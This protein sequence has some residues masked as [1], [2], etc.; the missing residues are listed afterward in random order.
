MLTRVKA[1]NSALGAL[2]IV[3]S[4]GRPAAAE[5]RPERR[6]SL[7]SFLHDLQ[8]SGLP[9]IFS[10]ALVR[11]GMDVVMK[12][13]PGSPRQILDDVLAPHGLEARDGPDGRLLVVEARR[14]PPQVPPM[15]G[16]AALKLVRYE[17]TVE[18]SGQSALT[19]TVGPPAMRALEVRDTPGGF[20]N[21]FRTL[22]LRPDVTPVNEVQGRFSVRS[23]SPDQNLTVVDGVEVFNPFRLEALMS[24]FD[25][26]TFESFELTTGVMPARYGDRLASVL[27]V[28]G[29]AGRRDRRWQGTT[30]L[31]FT[32]GSLTLEGRLPGN[33]DATWLISGRRTSLGSFTERL[34]GSKVNRFQDLHVRVDWPWRRRGRL[35]VW[36]L[37]GRD[38][39]RRV[40]VLR[41]SS[42]SSDPPWEVE[43]R[44]DYSARNDVWAAAFH[45]ALGPRLS[46][47][48]VFS[49][50]RNPQEA[51]ELELLLPAW[52]TWT[53]RHWRR[54]RL[55][56][57]ALREELAWVPSARQRWEGGFEIHRLETAWTMGG[58]GTLSRWSLYRGGTLALTPWGARG[59]TVEGGVTLEG[60][61]AVDGARSS[62]RSAVWLQDTVAVGE[63]LVIEPGLRLERSSVN[64]ETALSPRVHAAWRLGASTRLSGAWGWHA[65]SPGFEK[66]LLSDY[67]LD[68]GGEERLPVSSERSRQAVLGLEHRFGPGLSAR[69]ELYHTRFDRLI[70][71]RL[72]T[73]A[74]RQRRMGLLSLGDLRPGAMGLRA[75]DAREPLITSV[76][77]NG[78]RG[79]AR[80]AELGLRW[81]TP[82][83]SPRGLSGRFSYSYGR[84]R[85]ESYGLVYPFD[86]DRRHALAL[87]ADWRV[88][89]RW[90]LA[91]TWRAASGLPYTPFVPMLVA[92]VEAV[93]NVL[94]AGRRADEV[95]GVRL[96]D[97][98]AARH[99]FYSRVDL[100]AR[101]ALG[102][103]G[104]RGELYLDVFNALNHN[105]ADGNNSPSFKP[106]VTVTR[107]GWQVVERSRHPIL[108]VPSLGVRLRF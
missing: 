20:R 30:A 59:V 75:S 54:V 83:S 108:I 21:V 67:F 106:I 44:L 8:A 9:I 90:G 79:T 14:P 100:R 66:V 70:V 32:S 87:A 73:D 49:L 60:E 26:E 16:E 25:P 105:V 98:N 36:T 89:R 62:S 107:E 95:A 15:P 51:E 5:G 64:G 101:W 96:S 34:T 55:G 3:T 11:P 104:E 31:D 97:I 81:G 17:E 22:Q 86:Y 27:E 1:W 78:G 47:R 58:Q 6:Q 65:Q 40:P 93:D 61:A 69:L 19:A 71:G 99:P 28:H 33:E 42:G 68:Y 102:R 80:G 18:V 13:R 72:E 50:Y 88:S 7:A 24:A 35:S 103:R 38:Q 12:P 52:P 37:Q 91:A 56:D 29:R 2:V 82:S 45:G 41:G 4:L 76:P 10:E 94:A 43:R 85:R 74:Q 23:G 77:V 57:L 84:A 39:A 92:H 63:R 53:P 48:T 46:S